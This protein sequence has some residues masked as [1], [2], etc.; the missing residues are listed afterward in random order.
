MAPLGRRD[1][2]DAGRAPV[3]L[4]NHVRREKISLILAIF[5]K[6]A[7]GLTFQT[8]STRPK[9]SYFATGV[10]PWHHWT[11]LTSQKQA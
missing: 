7:S 8:P 9:T 1:K 10:A 3:C 4:R 6:M 2:P 11:A 5:A